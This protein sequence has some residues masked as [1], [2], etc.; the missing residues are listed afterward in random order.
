MRWS[1]NRELWAGSSGTGGPR[2]VDLRGPRARRLAGRP[3]AKVVHLR[4][5]RGR[6][7]RRALH[8]G[9]S[10]AGSWG[11][12]PLKFQKDS[13]LGWGRVGLGAGDRSHTG[14]APM[15]HRRP[16]RAVASCDTSSL[17]GLPTQAIGTE[18]TMIC[19]NLR[20]LW[21]VVHTR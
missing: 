20:C 15:R 10:W 7:L 5:A 6:G 18:V 9:G 3:T 12:G 11:T 14:Q 21:D 1:E 13:T 19:Q 2:P 17:G 8:V 16:S 4:P